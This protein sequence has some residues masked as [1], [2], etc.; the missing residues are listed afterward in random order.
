[1]TN[2]LP[3][4]L[5]WL[6]AK[7]WNR[8]NYLSFDRICCM[9][10]KT[11]SGCGTRTRGPKDYLNLKFSKLLHS[12]LCQPTIN[13]GRSG[14]IRT[15]GAISDSTVF[16]TVAIN[17]TLPRFDYLVWVAGFEPAASHFQGEPSGL[18]DNTPR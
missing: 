16:K 12:P 13:Y 9:Y 8:T 2:A 18:A 10:P 3:N 11:G 7:C 4:E 14:E 17:R 5:T 1:M 6:G 15:H